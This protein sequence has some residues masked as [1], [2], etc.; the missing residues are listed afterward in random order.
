MEVAAFDSA[1]S[2]PNADNTEHKQT[3]V[4]KS[5]GVVG[6]LL[7]LKKR[8][9]QLTGMYMLLVIIIIRRRNN[10]N[11]MIIFNLRRHNAAEFITRVPNSIQ[12]CFCRRCQ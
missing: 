3:A 4:T 11:N 9:Q 6:R 2:G 12:T 1:T 8:R 10:N 5:S 7:E